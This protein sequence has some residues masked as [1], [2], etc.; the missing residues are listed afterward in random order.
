M[1][2]GNLPA[3]AVTAAAGA[4]RDYLR[5]SGEAE[6]AVYARAAASAILIGEAHTGALFLR[7]AVEDVLPVRLD[8]AMLDAAPVQ[9]IAG[10]TALPVDTAPVVLPADAYAIDIDG[11]GR[12][13]VRAIAAQGAARVAVAYTAGIAVDWDSLPAP[14]AQGVVMLAAHLVEDRS[15]GRQPPAA[16]AALWRPWRRIQLAQVRA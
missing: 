9:A 15:A 5:V 4:V 1:T 7:R 8:W 3:V 10:L 6:A 16:V 12:G 13:W 2:L 14:L 11:D